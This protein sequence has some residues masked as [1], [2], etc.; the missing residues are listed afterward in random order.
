MASGDYD[1]NLSHEDFWYSSY[2]E[3][4]IDYR[5]KNYQNGITPQIILVAKKYQEDGVFAGTETTITRYVF[6]D[7]NGNI[8][9]PTQFYYTTGFAGGTALIQIAGETNWFVVDL[10]GNVTDTNIVREEWPEAEYDKELG[11][12][13]L[14]SSEEDT[15]GTYADING[16]FLDKKEMEKI[17][18]YKTVLEE[19]KD[20]ELWK[21]FDFDKFLSL[22]SM[23][24]LKDAII[25]N[26]I[27]MDDNSYEA[28]FSNKFYYSDYQIGKSVC[29]DLEENV[30]SGITISGYDSS[31]VYTDIGVYDWKGVKVS[32]ESDIVIYYEGKCYD[33]I[34]FSE[35]EYFAISF[36]NEDGI[37]TVY[38]CDGA[39][40]VDNSLIIVSRKDKEVE[41]DG[42]KVQQYIYALASLK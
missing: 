32:D 26:K 1:R 31:Y 24:E 33:N 39:K 34:Y 9:S 16:V 37:Y 41:V 36:L 20:L 25:D 18:L 38:A 14:R 42:V 29:I 10:E 21:R 28:T 19:T 2:A 8:L 11:C 23:T 6:K 13:F 27:H 5:V 4:A 7:T 12:Y 17:T 3:P 22:Y 35:K 15:I 40:N 30:D